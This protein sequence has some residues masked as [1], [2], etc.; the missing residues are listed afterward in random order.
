MPGLSR[1]LQADLT[2]IA[3]KA[4]EEIM[5]DRLVLV[6]GRLSIS[7]DALAGAKRAKAWP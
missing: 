6:A 3:E 4:G 5:Q 2:L 7:D 1:P